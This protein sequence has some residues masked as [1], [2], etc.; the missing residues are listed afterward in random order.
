MNTEE[1]IASGILELYV[2]GELSAAERREV[3]NNAAEYPAVRAEL[4]A[5]EAS[6]E[7][8][9]MS[10]S[11]EPPREVLEQIMEKVEPKQGAA[12]TIHMDPA[13]KEPLRWLRTL[14]YAASILLFVSVAGNIYYYNNYK[15]VQG[16]LADMQDQNQYMAG[17]VE[18]L[19]A[20]YGKL[21]ND[22]QV[23]AD[24]AFTAMTMRGLPISPDASS[25]VYWNKEEGSLY[26]IA[27]NLPAPVEG[28]QYQLWALKDGVPVDAGVF[29]V[30]GG[31]QHMHTITGA[32]GFAVTLEPA[33]GS[34]VPTLDQMYVIGNV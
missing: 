4:Q 13:R 16:Q 11:V 17:Q 22:M 27:N 14:A 15:N 23:I 9:A 3:E 24:P 31:L 33:G 32:Q 30:D 29:D 6:M 18:K 20:G 34:T 21:Q 1:Y 2:L 7:K 19:Q 8:L 26:I 25:V 10:M 5:I 12:K 28:K